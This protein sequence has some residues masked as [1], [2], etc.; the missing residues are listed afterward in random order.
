MWLAPQAVSLASG[1]GE[2]STELNAFDRALQ[3][4]RVAD[5]NFLRVTSLMP[6]RARLIDLPPH[7]PGLL[8]PA[9]YSRMTSTRAGEGIAAAI[10]VG[11]C[12]ERYGVIMEYAGRGS[13]AEADAAVRKMVE[14][15]LRIRGLQADE[16]VTAWA[17]HTVHRA[18]S[19]VAVALFWPTPTGLPA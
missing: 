7:P 3:D 8:L 13:G 11:I 1:H 19:A 15:G 5:I 4:A 17:E 6:P 2:G 10:G 9:V 14:E 12:R 16:I 18:G